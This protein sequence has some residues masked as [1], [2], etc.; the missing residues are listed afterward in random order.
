MWYVVVGKKVIP[1]PCEHDENTNFL[2][3][4][5]WETATP[6][7]VRAEIKRGADVNARETTP[8]LLSERDLEFERLKENGEVESDFHV[9][10]VGDT[11]HEDSAMNTPMHYALRRSIDDMKEV[12]YYENILSSFGKSEKLNPDFIKFLAEEFNCEETQKAAHALK[13]KLT[14]EHKVAQERQKMSEDIVRIMVEN[15]AKFNYLATFYYS[16]LSLDSFLNILDI[17][18][19]G[20]LDINQRIRYWEKTTLIDLAASEGQKKVVKRLLDAGAKDTRTIMQK[21]KMCLS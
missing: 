10:S 17:L 12:C 9:P 2:N 16:Y 8:R 1:V 19:E 18:I 5:W 14:Q 13:P 4:D 3:E 6:D 7:D 11:S 15:G 21:I 20:G